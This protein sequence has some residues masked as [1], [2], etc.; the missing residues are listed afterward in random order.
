MADDPAFDDTAVELPPGRDEPPIGRTVATPGRL[1]REARERAGL[2][3]G[4]LA[5]TLKVSP[6]KLDA[7]EGDR[8]DELPDATFARALALSVC[9]ALR[10][11]PAP[12]LEAFAAA[13]LPS[14]PLRGAGRGLN[15][16]I[17][18]GAGAVTLRGHS[19]SA[20][21]ARWWVA[22]VVVI[23]LAGLALAW[24]SPSWTLAGGPDAQGV[25]GTVSQ[26]VPEPAAQGVFSETRRSLAPPLFFRVFAKLVQPDV[27]LV[28]VTSG[29]RG[30]GGAAVE[31]VAAPSPAPDKAV[32]GA[33]TGAADAASGAPEAPRLAITAARDSWVEVSEASGRVVWARVLAA[34]QTLKPEVAPPLRLVIG[35]A[36]ATQVVF[37]GRE[38]DLA[39][40]SRGN[41]ARI[42]IP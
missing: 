37:D 2:H 32:A 17:R 5:S 14:D 1:L 16:P 22:I 40:V 28:D 23:A 10:C 41:V 26:V 42:D 13:D 39:P 31:A 15:A 34:G 9:R 19:R 36:R 12:V 4:V 18:R 21:R 30:P 6:R 27:A 24:W 29:H 3:V 7:L 11:D 33:S 38:L 20:P 25:T 8:Y 35:N